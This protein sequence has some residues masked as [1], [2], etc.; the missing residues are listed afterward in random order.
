MAPLVKTLNAD[1]RFEHRVCVT[2]QH[3]EMLDEV[4]S[5]CVGSIIISNKDRLTRM[6]FLTL[7]SICDKFHTK[8]II[9][10]KKNKKSDDSDIFEELISMMDYFSTKMYSNRKKQ[11]IFLQKK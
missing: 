11:K 10:S 7:Q 4:F 1:E 5:G 2:G 6:S 3:R 8:I 9:V